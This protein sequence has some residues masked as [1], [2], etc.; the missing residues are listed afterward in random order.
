MVVNNGEFIKNKAQ[1][2]DLFEKLRKKLNSFKVINLAGKT[3]GRIK[4][5]TLDKSRRLYMVIPQADGVSDSP[6]YLLSS[7]Y[8]Q[9]VDTS[10]RAVFVDISQTEIKEL[11]LYQYSNSTERS[12]QSPT[13]TLPEERISSSERVL[14]LD[15][16]QFSRI[17]SSTTPN[18]KEVGR[19]SF[20][21][22]D[23]S[24]EVV[25]EQIVALLEE[26][27]IVN[28]SKR[29]L[30]EIVVRKEI[31]TRIIEVPVQ[32][33]K[34]IIEKVGSE[35]KQPVEVEQL[36]LDQVSQDRITE[37]SGYSSIRSGTQPSITNYGE[38]QPS[39]G[40]S[41]TTENLEEVDNHSFPESDD[42]IEVAEEEIVRLL[43][44][45]LIVNR[46]KWKVGEV[47]VRKEVETQI[48]Q[49]PIHREKLII[50]QV[51]PQTRQI[52]EIDLGQEDVSGVELTKTPRSDA[53]P[54]SV[55]S[56]DSPYTVVGEF[57]SPKAASHL[58]EAIALQKYHGC[59]KVRV[60]LVVDNPELQ[61]AYQTM[62]DR[63]SKG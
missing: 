34:L 53:L 23:E 43:E 16:N 55:P 5:F 28:R 27:L 3:I 44:E 54:P 42:V 59:A 57:F 51:S 47:V 58:L 20:V 12:A 13:S 8:I 60:E 56:A 33:E 40:Q 63:C 25:E 9:K 35:S 48:V 11:P 18:F 21:E 52:A 2:N 10:N 49:V 30:G 37:S 15:E 50:E 31:E 24:P 26:R 4:D 1:I 17:Q 41:L 61:E 39:R 22:S 38:T 36:P 6:V 7:K 45:R 62:F 14:S 29:K 19:E 46:S 32:S